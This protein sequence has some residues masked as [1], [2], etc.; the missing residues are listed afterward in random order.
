MNN[1]PLIIGLVGMA[2]SGKDT[3]AHMMSTVV[4]HAGVHSDHLA[5]ADPI[6]D[7]GERFGFPIETMTDQS[8]KEGWLHP[9]FNI[10]PRKFMQKVGTEM[11]R[12]QLDKDVWVKLLE[13][14]LIE[15]ENS[16]KNEAAAYPDYEY[17]INTKPWV[18]KNVIFITDVRF[19]N[20]AEMLKR[21]GGFIIKIERTNFVTSGEWRKHESEKYIDDIEK[22][23][24][25]YNNESSAFEWGGNAVMLFGKFCREHNIVIDV[26]GYTKAG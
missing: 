7:I 6:R 2:K 22:D 20:E 9:V 10:T 19:P 5:F 14:K 24:T 23:A 1:K 16:A 3:A 26:P 18:P 4:T 11:F 21:H 12:D 17:D 13:M 25:W 15:A 8:L